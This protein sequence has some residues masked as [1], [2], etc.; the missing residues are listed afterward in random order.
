MAKRLDLTAASTKSKLRGF[1][2]LLASW[3]H[4]VLDFCKSRDHQDNPWWYNERASLSVLAGAAWRLKGWTALEEFS[5]TKRGIVPEDQIDP[6]RI[7]RGRCDLHVAHRTTG[8][9]IEAKQAWQCIGKRAQA[10]NVSKAMEKAWKD[11]GNL[12]SDEGDHRLAL[13]FVA[14]HLAVSEV[15]EKRSRGDALI[16]E[17]L[18]R[19]KVEGWLESLELSAMDAHAFVFPKRAGGFI[20]TR[21]TLVFPGV[22]IC[23]KRRL[24]ANRQSRG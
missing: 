22:L 19:E 10:D 17:D 15:G 9:A 4:S 6:G 13:T 23:I 20:N 5:T 3:T 8:F 2:P 1:Q 12:T 24:K 16:N 11:A 7:V 18:V 14:P 21:Q